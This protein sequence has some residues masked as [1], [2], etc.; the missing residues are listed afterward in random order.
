MSD[1]H[2]FERSHN[3][4]IKA[5][6]AAV[7]D[8]V[9]NP[10]SWPEWLASSHRIE[11]DDRPM[12]KDDTFVEQW[13][14]RSGPAELHWVVTDCNP[15]HLWVGETKAAFLGPII[16]RYDVT[17]PDAD[18]MVRFT[19]SMINPARPKPP[20][21]DQITRMDAEAETALA[22]IKR[23]VEARLKT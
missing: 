2:A 20:T 19:R 21:E 13:S 7:L 17:E 5:P 18:G 10:N 6:S 3:I 22:N 23:N 9:S 11:A 16:V 1:T 14:T 12:R 8:Y 15:P 4:M